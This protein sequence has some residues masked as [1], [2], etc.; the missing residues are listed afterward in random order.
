MC[1]CFKASSSFL[2]LMLYI[3]VSNLPVIGLCSGSQ[4][5]GLPACHNSVVFSVCIHISAVGMSSASRISCIYW[6]I[7]ALILEVHLAAS[8]AEFVIAE[9]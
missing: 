7:H 8:D 6:N 1:K 5:I 2:H 4:C 3:S 9:K